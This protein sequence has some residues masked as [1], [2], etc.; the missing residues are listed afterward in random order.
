MVVLLICTTSGCKITSN[1]NPKAIGLRTNGVYVYDNKSDTLIKNYDL[2]SEFL[3]AVKS[4]RIELDSSSIKIAEKFSYALMPGS[5]MVEYLR[6][7]KD[8]TA[9]CIILPYHDLKLAFGILD[10]MRLVK[11]AD[12][13]INYYSITNDSSISFIAGK[14]NSMTAIEYSGKV[15]G[16]SLVLALNPLRLSKSAMYHLGDSIRVYKFIKYPNLRTGRIK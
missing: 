12:S 10:S 8:R 9:V 5:T 7:Q 13:F 6:F 2:Q 4:G 15:C 1:F 16:D 3:E 14:Y 11:G